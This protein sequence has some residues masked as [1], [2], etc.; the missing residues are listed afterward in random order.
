MLRPETR[1]GLSR[2]PRSLGGA[3]D[4]PPTS[5]GRTTQAFCPQHESALRTQKDLLRPAGCLEQAGGL[6][7]AA[8]AGRTPREPSR[9]LTK[10][11]PGTPHALRVLRDGAAGRTGTS[12]KVKACKWFRGGPL[13]RRGPTPP[14]ER[15][16]MH[17]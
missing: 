14:D 6:I 10:R 3:W 7:P 16:E 2:W 8:G 5:H 15:P 1:Q 17:K 11:E 9:L 12:P 4:H 13:Q